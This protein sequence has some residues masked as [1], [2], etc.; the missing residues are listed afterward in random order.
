MRSQNIHKDLNLIGDELIEKFILKDD[1]T[2]K[3]VNAFFSDKNI[4]SHS[5]N[6]LDQFTD[7]QRKI[8]IEELTLQYSKVE[9]SEQTSRNIKLLSNSKTLSVTTG[10]QL[11]IFSGPLMVI[12]KIA[13]VISITNSLNSNIKG[14]NYVPIFW[15]ASEDHDFEE[16]SEVNLKENK[17]KWNLDSK[18]MPVGEIELNNFMEVVSGY[19]NS[20]IDFEFKDK[21]EILIDE[22]YKKGDTLSA[23]TIKFINSLFGKHGLVIVDS[24]KKAFKKSFIENF[25]N[26]ILDSRCELDSSS[27]ILKI[28]K[29]IKSFKPQVNPSDVNFFKITSLGRKRIRKTDKLFRVDDENEYTSGDLINQIET[30]PELFSPNVLMRPLY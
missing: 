17:I 22:A 7:Y 14:F 16:I 5:K 19:K 24:N 9:T 13:H 1:K 30:N 6:K 18:N 23:A 4:L 11:N 10:H 15:I 25:K 29:D 26:E 12:Y 8:L 27:Q 2:S 20:I 21:L 3:Y 28:K